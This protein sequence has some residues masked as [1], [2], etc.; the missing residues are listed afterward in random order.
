MKWKKK[1][2]P[3]PEFELYPIVIRQSR[4][5][6]VYEGGAWVAFPNSYRFPEGAFGDDIE[7]VDY[8]MSTQ[9]MRIGRGGT[10]DE[11]Y[12]D[13]VKRN[14][15]VWAED[16]YAEINPP[17]RGLRYRIGRRLISSPKS[18]NANAIFFE[19]DPFGG[20]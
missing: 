16:A 11:A 5:S 18:G 6:G 8:W 1:H 7:A 10:P 3:D 20:E 9:S 12:R 17:R 19:K 4:Y 15:F 2:G 14:A 13:L